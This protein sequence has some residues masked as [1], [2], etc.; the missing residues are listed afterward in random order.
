MTPLTDHAL[1][2][3]LE[4]A[5]GQGNAS[6][7]DVQ[8]RREPSSGATWTNIGGTVAMFSGVGSPLTQTFGLGITATPSDDELG[9]LE[10]FFT[11]RGADTVHEVS[12]LAGVELFARLTGRGYKPVELSS[13]M[14]RPVGGA[15][16]NTRVNPAIRV[17]TVTPAEFDLYASVSGRGWSES[18]EIQGFIAGFARISLEYATCIVAEIDGTAIATA[19]LFMSGGVG[20]LAGASTVP[21]GRRQGAQSA[22]LDWRLKHLAAAGCDLAMMV[23]AP[24][25]ASQRNAERNEFRIAYTRTK[26][27]RSAGI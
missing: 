25:S 26:W 21:E 22:L 27:Q 20:L 23:A 10:A 15:L 24:G 18:A 19:A 9:A 7:V 1:S 11:S 13:V 4:L 16:M 8:A 3:R 12:P 2:A 5:E 17:R 6:F 14:F